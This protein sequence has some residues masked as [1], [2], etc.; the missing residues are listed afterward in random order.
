MLNETS[1]IVNRIFTSKNKWLILELKP[2]VP[3]IILFIIIYLKKFSTINFIN[4][5]CAHSFGKSYISLNGKLIWKEAILIPIHFGWHNEK[6]SELLALLFFILFICLFNKCIWL[7]QI[8]LFL[9]RLQN[10]IKIKINIIKKTIWTIFLID[11]EK[12]L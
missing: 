9:R 5:F 6:Y 3:G 7:I 4:K 10:Q 2:K 8:I 11:L 1:W 12:E